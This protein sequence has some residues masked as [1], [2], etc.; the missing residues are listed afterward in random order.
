SD[1]ANS[2]IAQA[3]ALMR[4]QAEDVGTPEFSSAQEANI[5]FLEGMLAARMGDTEGAQANAA[6]FE[7]HSVTNTNPRKLE[8]MHEI[9]G[10]S[11]FYQGDF[12]GAAK[13]LAAGD[14]VNNMYTKYHLA[15]ANDKAGNPA[16]ASRLFNE[17]AAWNFNGPGYAL[18]R[19]EILARAASD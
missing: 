3:A 17:L 15:L 7:R 12:A 9:L 13:R 8:R 4:Q 2:V 6:A 1:T 18:T 14:V 5:A 10:M 19:G 11:D 16:E